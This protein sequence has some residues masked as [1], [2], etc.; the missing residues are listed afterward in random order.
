MDAPELS[1]P[2]RRLKSELKDDGIVIDADEQILAVLLDELEHA[3][4]PQQ[5]ERRTPLYGSMIVPPDR[6]LIE[7]G[8]LVDLIPLDGMP[9]EEARRFADGRSTYLAVGPDG[10]RTLACFRRSVQY[11]ADMVEIQSD[12][13]AFIVQRTP[14][15]GVT[16][17][18]TPTE[19]IEWTGYRWTQ[20]PNARAQHELLQPF[21]PHITSAVLGG[22]LELA[23][24][25]LSP[26]RVG[27]TLVVPVT[28]GESGL[29]LSRAIA[30]PDLS[31]T[32]RHH[33]PALL[34]A[35][36]Q[37]DLATVIDAAGRPHHIGVGLHWSG[38]AEQAIEVNG[39][40]RHRSAARYTYD[41][42]DAVAIVVSE[43]G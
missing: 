19:T 24:H 32:A 26:G 15:L 31:V 34:G 38:E 22:L 42:R 5:F 12:T 3:R 6:S 10:S 17:L 29:D 43:D 1:R 23:V 39:G 27:A 2:V 41:H 40:M 20:R 28:H 9:L 14:V 13:G 21:L 35:L 4:R 11:E 30:T 18:F 33:Y 8:E 25:W 16:R 36:L 37:T 7:A